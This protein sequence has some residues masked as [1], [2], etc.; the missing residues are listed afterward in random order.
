M[1]AHRAADAA[2]V[3]PFRVD[4]PHARAHMCVE[5]QPE[6]APQA[7]HPPHSL[8]LDLTQLRRLARRDRLRPWPMRRS[9]SRLF[10]RRGSTPTET[11]LGV[12]P[13]RAGDVRR[14]WPSGARGG[15]E[16]PRRAPPPS[17]GILGAAS[18]PWR[19]RGGFN[20]CGITRRFFRSKKN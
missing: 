16:L 6:N 9:G 7:P 10:G 19:R 11:R 8:L 14:C 3:A 2:L 4:R 12:R 13:H 5:A 15:E 1:K 20:L 17:W 18:D